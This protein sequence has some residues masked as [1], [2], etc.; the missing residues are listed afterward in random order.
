MSLIKCKECGHVV[1]D[2]AQSCPHCGVPIESVVTC[3]ECG[4]VLPET[5][6]TC[7]N[8]GCPREYSS[9]SEAVNVDLHTQ[10]KK[11]DDAQCRSSRHVEQVIS[12]SSDSSADVL[13][14]KSKKKLYAV[15]LAMIVILG[16]VVG[17]F[18]YSKY[19]YTK[20]DS[21]VYSEDLAD[22]ANMGNSDAQLD[23]SKVYYKE[24]KYKEC[25]EWARKS[26]EKGNTEAQALLFNLY[27]NGIGTDANEKE[28]LKWLKKASEGGNSIAQAVLAFKYLSELN[29]DEGMKW[30]KKSASAGYDEA[31]VSLAEFY[32]K[33]E[34]VAKDYLEATKWYAEAAKKGNRKA[35]VWLCSFYESG[36]L[37]PASNE[38]ELLK[39]YGQIK[40]L[41]DGI[42]DYIA[43]KLYYS[44]QTPDA[45]RQAFNYVNKAAQ[46]GV[47][48]AWTMLGL[49]HANGQGVEQSD[50]KAVD[51]FKKGA[52]L[53]DGNAEY[54][55]GKAYQTG[56]VVAQDKTRAE[57]LF[58]KASQKNSL[59]AHQSSLKDRHRNATDVH[60]IGLNDIFNP[61]EHLNDNIWAGGGITDS[62]VDNLSSKGY[63]LQNETIE[64]RN[65]FDPQTEETNLVT[66][67]I[68]FYGINNEFN[69]DWEPL[70]E[71]NMGVI[72][73]REVKDNYIMNV[74]LTFKSG[75]LLRRFLDEAQNSG[76]CQGESNTLSRGEGLTDY[77]VVNDNTVVCSSEYG[78]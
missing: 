10:K 36:D 50:E 49:M 73:R 11:A 68:L 2:K 38:E 44:E 30:L 31:Q 70:H 16:G 24:K 28:G 77:I 43:G 8:C 6:S 13:E 12:G 32:S 74:T 52:E 9:K 56:T 62:L 78:Y 27:V 7:P 35:Q 23:L 1:S 18:Y 59:Q 33:G 58:W 42:L 22:A 67:E 54:F 65:V 40:E 46:K 17:T 39:L 37:I 34:G 47:A 57:E 4:T 19:S 25:F 5:S 21:P 29:Y 71:N 51:C 64:Q 20:S 41:G 26:A 15:V 55:L 76:F 61:A 45:L 63:R 72:I 3:A 48:P 66:I 53:G 14:H 75:K 69:R 60:Y